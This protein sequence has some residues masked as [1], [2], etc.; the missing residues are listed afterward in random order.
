VEQLAS[1][2]VVIIS[3]LA[4]GIDITSHKAALLQSL[5][6]IAVLGCGLDNIYPPVHRQTA[7]DM[8]ANG[9]LVT[10]FGI[11]TKLEREHFPMRNRIIA[12]L[13]D[14]LVVVQSDVKGG[15]M[16][17][18]EMANSYNRDVYTYPGKIG[19]TQHRGC[20][21]LIKTNRAALIENGE[22]L[23]MNLQIRQEEA[24]VLTCG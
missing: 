15:S 4:Y 10:E 18:A 14:A 6:T 22:D 13:C 17:T 24:A 11:G 1:Y 8:L 7:F 23:A 5:P 2:Q 12:G 16:I 9:G 3:G 21:F 19:E 20:H